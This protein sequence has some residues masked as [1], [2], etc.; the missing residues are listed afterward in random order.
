[1]L[2][3]SNFT[4]IL[5]AADQL[6]IEDQEDLI[7][8]LQNRLRDRRRAELIKEVQEAQREFALGQCQPTTPDQLMQELLS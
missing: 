1:M 4:K 8:I 7:K 3:E 6:L 2:V 5:E